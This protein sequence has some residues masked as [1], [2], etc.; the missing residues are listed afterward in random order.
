MFSISSVFSWGDLLKSLGMNFLNVAVFVLV[1]NLV[2]YLTFRFLLVFG[3]IEARLKHFALRMGWLVAVGMSVPAI[4]LLV[5][6][7]V[8]PGLLILGGASILLLTRV[9][10]VQDAIC[11]FAISLRLGCHLL[12]HRKKIERLQRAASS[13]VSLEHALSEDESPSH[14]RVEQPSSPEAAK[15]KKDVNERFAVEQ[16]VEKTLFGTRGQTTDEM[17]KS[18]ADSVSSLD[19]GFGFSFA[20]I[21]AAITEYIVLY[22]LSIPITLI[23]W[24]LTLE[25]GIRAVWPMPLLLGAAVALV[26]Y[27][28]I[29]IV[30]AVRWLRFQSACLVCGQATRSRVSVGSGSTHLCSATCQDKLKSL[31]GA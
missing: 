8:T 29:R 25:P 27:L 26:L 24:G 11:E 28:A 5:H 6:V 22:V 7:K 18:A 15:L 12:R 2:L 19:S 30:R 16:F 9:R 13:A 21:M 10:S 4:W 23:A 17:I 14:D 1:V 3:I 20:P 31:F